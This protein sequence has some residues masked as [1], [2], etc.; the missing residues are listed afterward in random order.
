MK[1]T[2]M[3]ILLTLLTMGMY[4]SAQP[5]TSS[6]SRGCYLLDA[7]GNISL[8]LTSPG[9]LSVGT[10]VA[11]EYP[12]GSGIL[13]PATLTT[14]LPSNPVINDDGTNYDYLF[15]TSSAILLSDLTDPAFTMPCFRV[16]YNTSG[17]T[18]SV[19]DP[20]F[21]VCYC[22][23]VSSGCYSKVG[24][25]YVFKLEFSN[26]YYWVL[27]NSGAW[28]GTP[29]IVNSA[30]ILI[31]M[32]Y[33]SP[34]HSTPNYWTADGTHYFASYKIP[35]SDFT[36]NPQTGCIDVSFFNLQINGSNPYEETDHNVLHWPILQ[37]TQ[38]CACC[39]QSSYDFS[40]SG[41]TGSG[42]GFTQHFT[43]GMV[44]NWTFGDGSTGS[45]VSVSHT[46]ALPGTYT[47][48]A[49]SVTANDEPCVKCNTFC[50]TDPNVTGTSGGL[51]TDCDADFN[52]S[53]SSNTVNV[54]NWFTMTGGGY[55]SYDFGD[56]TPLVFGTSGY[57][58]HTYATAGVYT[59]CVVAYVNPIGSGFYIN[60]S[61]CMNICVTNPPVC[62]KDP[63]EK[64]SSQTGSHI[65]QS[66][67]EILIAPNPTDK[68]TNIVFELEKAS[69]VRVTVFDEVGRVVSD[70]TKAGMESGTQS[71]ELN[72][73]DMQPGMYIVNV[74]TDKGL[75]TKRLTI[76]K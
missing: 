50:L 68:M 43:A 3:T 1:Q 16:Y 29:A 73:T 18:V 46:Y 40:V 33:A 27:H 34:G 52:T 20:S 38:V 35:V 71:I 76:I 26:F 12:V 69:D 7:R 31:D 19:S 15:S 41:T 63:G 6:F 59:I 4:V 62:C 47:V 51:G 64:S 61:K 48:C 22:S 2:L 5:L 65:V 28:T 49:S 70:F 53:V 23:P 42:S 60:C 32:G 55:F 54:V 58:S 57:Q 44:S 39:R 36:P 13:I 67:N 14:G 74:K 45:G 30:G 66:S 17:G 8:S 24:S 10:T 37:T 9:S 11:Y 21:A 72:T 25:D 75:R 56:G